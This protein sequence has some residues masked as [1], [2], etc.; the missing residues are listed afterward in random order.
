MRD[1]SAIF[2]LSL[3]PQVDYKTPRAPTT[4]PKN[5]EQIIKTNRAF[6]VYTPNTS[7]NE[8]WS[9]GTPYPTE[10]LIESHDV[11]Q[12]F[13]ER[14]SSQRLGQRAFAAFGDYTYT[15]L[16]G[17]QRHAFRPVNPQV[18][19]G[20]P[21]FTYVEKAGEPALPADVTHD[22][23]CP[24][25]FAESFSVRGEGRAFLMGTTAWRGSGKLITPSGVTFNGA[26]SH[27]RLEDEQTHNFFRST[28]ASLQLY[29]N[30]SF[31]GAPLGVECDFRNFTFTL[32]NNPNNDAGY[33]G[34]AEYQTANDSESGA[35]RSN[36]TVGN[37]TVTVEYTLLMTG[38]VA[39]T[40]NPYGKAKL[41]TYFSSAL[42]YIGKQIGVSAFNHSALWRFAKQTV[43]AVQIDSIDNLF[44]YRIT[45]QPLALGLVMPVELIVTNDVAAYGV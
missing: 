13:E 42:E 44:A 6:A 26:G 25:F 14:M 19:D 9:T 41:Q 34:C 12:S 5:Y 11:T 4:A 2:A 36:L 40:F 7:N 22:L 33:N 39:Q 8:G 17:A 30:A 32:N 28:S 16:A 35:I 31:S 45:P 20:L 15:A 3:L 24:S 23:L 18:A 10:Q 29:P 21:V 37:Q 38:A 43:T 27:V 1:S